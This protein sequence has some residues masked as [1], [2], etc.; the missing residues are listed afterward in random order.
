M[1]EAEAPERQM[2]RSLTALD[3][4][5]LGIGAIIGTGI[6]ALTGTAAAGEPATTA[7]SHMTTPV[8]NFIQSWISGAET[9]MGRPGAGPGRRLFLHDCGAGLRVCGA[10]LRRAGLDDPGLGLGVHLFLRDLGRDRR[11][12]HRLGFDPRICGRQHGG[13]GRMVGLLCE[14]VL[15]LVRARVSSLGGD[16]HE[17]CAASD[18][19]WWR[20]AAG[21]FV[22]GAPDD[23][24]ECLS[25]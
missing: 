21:L 5:A 9:V 8:I 19:E 1:R 17:D 11:M 15:Q 7:A 14:A 10:L 25:R 4:T 3:L 18:R 2:K 20:R 13:R 6:F 12:D 24:R 23:R 16:R 22:D